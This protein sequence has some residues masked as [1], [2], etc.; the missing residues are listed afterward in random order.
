MVAKRE[1]V[2]DRVVEGQ[3]VEAREERDRAERG[4]RAG[5]GAGAP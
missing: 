2:D 4:V 5:A 1:V 3:K